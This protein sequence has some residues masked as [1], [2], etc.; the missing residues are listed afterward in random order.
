[1]DTQQRQHAPRWEEAKPFFRR[2]GMLRDIQCEGSLEAWRSWLQALVAAAWSLEFRMSGE[3]V[4]PSLG[5]PRAAPD[6]EAP[7]LR[8]LLATGPHLNTFFFDPDEVDADLAPEDF[9]AEEQWSELVK[10]MTLLGDATGGSVR[11]SPEGDHRHPWLIYTPGQ[12]AW[13][14]IGDPTD[15]IVNEWPLRD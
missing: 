1:M 13:T 7:V 14:T 3:L 15:H 6:D 10:F 2:D 11:L 4:T 12:G 8:V 9:V 5:F